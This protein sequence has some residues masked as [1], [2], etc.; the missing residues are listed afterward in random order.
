MTILAGAGCPD[1]MLSCLITRPL[2]RMWPCR[3]PRQQRGHAFLN[4]AH[5]ISEDS[6][7]AFFSFCDVWQMKIAALAQHALGGLPRVCPWGWGWHQRIPAAT[8]SPPG[9]TQQLLVPPGEQLLPPPAKP[10]MVFQVSAWSD[11]T[12]TDQFLFFIRNLWV[13]KCDSYNQISA[14]SLSFSLYFTILTGRRVISHKHVWVVSVFS[15]WI[16]WM[17]LAWWFMRVSIPINTPGTRPGWIPEAATAAISGFRH[18]NY[19]IPTDLWVNSP[20]IF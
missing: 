9:A 1:R 5:L 8:H 4:S 3:A 16:N 12:L 6:G 7:A 20:I 17:V 2:I 10:G 14:L 18:I 19:Y 13:Y 15:W 11:W